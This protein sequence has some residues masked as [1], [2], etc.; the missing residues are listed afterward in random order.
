MT[1]SFNRHVGELLPCS[2]CLE[3]DTN[4][5]IAHEGLGNK[6]PVHF[7]CLT[8][9]LEINETCPACR[10][11]V[12]IDSVY[13]VFSWSER[14]VQELKILSQKFNYKKIMNWALTSGLIGSLLW[15]PELA[16]GLANPSLM[17]KRLALYLGSGATAGIASEALT[18]M[19][20]LTENNSQKEGLLIASVGATLSCIANAALVAC[21]ETTIAATL[22][23]ELPVDG[24]LCFK[25]VLLGGVI[26]VVSILT[27][28]GIC[29]LG[30][31]SKLTGRTMQ[32]TQKINFFGPLILGAAVA[33]TSAVSDKSA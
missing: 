15:V 7:K 3:N 11:K 1:V 25:A 21:G 13:S 17:P 16:L 12:N 26:G 14:Y 31:K 24:G 6:H 30:L 32:L 23:D 22:K 5:L 33:Y 28:E 10:E 29:R 18:L 4:S 20:S 27:L 2:V 9:W 19:D 8:K